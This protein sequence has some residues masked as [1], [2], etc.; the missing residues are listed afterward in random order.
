MRLV[1]LPGSEDRPGNTG[2]L[3]RE[4][5]GRDIRVGSS[6]ELLEPRTEPVGA[7]VRPAQDGT[8]PVDQETADRAVASLGDAEEPGLPPG[9]RLAG[10]EPEQGGQF[11]S[12]PER[13]PVADGGHQRGG[14]ERSDPRN[15]EEPLAGR[16]VLGPGHDGPGQC[17]DPPIERLDPL[18]EIRHQLPHPGREPVR[19]IRQDGGHTQTEGMDPLGIVIPSSRRNARSWL[20]WAVR[21]PTSTTT[22]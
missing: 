5:H 2:Q 6:P 16:I 18:P 14:R 4:R 21:C 9:G 15:R 11:P 3:V 19:G 17:P 7:S 20:I 10:H 12:P 22:C 1:D 8:G 13:L